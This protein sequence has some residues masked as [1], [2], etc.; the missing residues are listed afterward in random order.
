MKKKRAALTFSLESIRYDV[1][2]A[3]TFKHITLVDIFKSCNF[4]S[5]TKKRGGD[6]R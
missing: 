5:G 6:T 2:C 4:S 3:V 1:N